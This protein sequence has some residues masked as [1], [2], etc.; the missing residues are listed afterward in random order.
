MTTGTY[1]YQD[2]WKWFLPASQSFLKPSG[3]P[4]KAKHLLYRTRNVT[5]T[6]R[7]NNYI[8]YIFLSQGPIE[9]DFFPSTVAL[10]SAAQETAA[11][12]AA[13][14]AAQEAVKEASVSSTRP[15]GAPK[16]VT[17]APACWVAGLAQGLSLS[18]PHHGGGYT[19]YIF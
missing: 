13:A 6:I 15:P 10:N 7:I 2:R 3:P 18:R 14:K 17:Q 11:H 19:R 5:E 1:R 16:A 9:K 12:Q 4:G 8:P